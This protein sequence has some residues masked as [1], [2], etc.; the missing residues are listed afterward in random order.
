MARE[1][2]DA[3]KFFRSQER[4]YRSQAAKLYRRWTLPAGC[5]AED[6]YQE[7]LLGAWRA[8]CR[9]WARWGDSNESPM[10]TLAAYCGVSAVQEARRWMMVQR[11]TVRRSVKAEARY[12]SPESEFAVT[13]DG[14]GILDLAEVAPQA[15]QATLVAEVLTMLGGGHDPAVSGLVRA[16]MAVRAQEQLVG[17]LDDDA[18]V[19]PRYRMAG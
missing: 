5:S 6:V 16:A 2:I 14:L 1:K 12:P 10:M 7:M 17:I 15:E 8:W 13:E 18:P 4:Q 11:N 19:A 3:T 9:W